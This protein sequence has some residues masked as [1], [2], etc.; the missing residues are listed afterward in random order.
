VLL[1]I[2]FG[3]AAVIGAACVLTGPAVPAGA[4]PP[5]GGGSPQRVDETAGPSTVTPKE[6]TARCP[7][8][9]YLFAAGAKVV[10]G[11]G[12]VVLTAIVPDPAVRSV[13]VS[14]TA[15]DWYDGSWSLVAFAICDWSGTPPG[16]VVE[17]EDGESTVTASCPGANRLTGIGFRLDGPVE[18]IGVREVA[19]GPERRD[20]RVGAGGEGTPDSLTAYGI[21]KWPSGPAGVVVHN[22]GT[23]DSVWPKIATASDTTLD[24]RVYAAAATVTGPGDAFLTALVPNVNQNVAWAEATRSG[25]LAA[26][27]RR[28]ADP[29]DDD[30][31]D[32]TLSASALLSGTFH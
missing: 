19:I 15:R 1:S 14:A 20:A 29:D 23:V 9:T 16:V 28:V 2:R 10:D 25:P 5:L 13:T 11:N 18:S 24:M 27:G 7:D 17:T 31:V 26:D 8:D 21:C 6:V 4:D 30:E 3:V 22:P 12:G 32:G